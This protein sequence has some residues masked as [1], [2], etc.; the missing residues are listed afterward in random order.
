MSIKSVVLTAFAA[1]LVVLSARAFEFIVATKCAN[2]VSI[3]NV[4]M[5]LVMGIIVFI[6]VLM[7]K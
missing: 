2:G 5:P 4:V 3:F 6:I 1:F 7:Y